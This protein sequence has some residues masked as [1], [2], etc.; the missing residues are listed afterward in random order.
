M[1]K[2]DGPMMSFAASGTLAN[3]VVF[4]SWKGRAYVRQRVI[5][6][7]PKSGAQVGRRVQFKFLTQEWA[8]LLTAVKATWQDKADQLVAS[9][10][11]AYLSANMQRWHNF[12]APGQADPAAESDLP[13]D[14]ALAIADWEENRIMFGSAIITANE[15]WGTIVFASLDT[16]FDTSVGNAIMLVD[17]ATVDTFTN[18]WTPPTVDTWFL[19]MRPFSREGV[20]AAATGEQSSGAP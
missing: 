11:N 20:L 17:H 6:S 18:Y 19:N 16:G 13:S 14:D 9:P 7:N 5:P 3:T 2:V 1:V 15:A 8:G 10:F 4:S 12:M